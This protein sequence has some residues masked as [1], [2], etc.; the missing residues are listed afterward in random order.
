MSMADTLALR[1]RLGSDDT[2]LAGARQLCDELVR[3]G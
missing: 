1:V 2:G 3:V